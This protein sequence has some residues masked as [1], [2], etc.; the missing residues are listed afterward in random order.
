MSNE[1]GAEASSAGLAL[2]QGRRHHAVRE[3]VAPHPE[4]RDSDSGLRYTVILRPED[5]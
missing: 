4:N 3:K 5:E 1:H 2:R